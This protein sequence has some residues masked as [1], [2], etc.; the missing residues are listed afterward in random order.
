MAV[1]YRQQVYTCGDYKQVRYY[2]VAPARKGKGRKRKVRP[3][4]AAQRWIN[5]RQREDKAARLL[6]ANF[7]AEDTMLSLTYA[8]GCQPDTAEE[9]VRDV[10]NYLRRVKY[11][12]SRAGLP[13]PRY[14]WVPEGDG[15]NKRFHVHMTITSGLP[16]KKLQELWGQVVKA[17]DSDLGSIAFAQPLRFTRGGV[18]A[19]ARYFM[20]ESREELE[21]MCIDPETGEITDAPSG[22]PFKKAY[23]CSQGL[24]DPKPETSVISQQAVTD[25]CTVDAGAR[26]PIEKRFPGWMMAETHAH[27]DETVGRWYLYA[28]LY[29]VGSFMWRVKADEVARTE[30]KKQRAYEPEEDELPW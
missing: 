14:I 18:E 22:S 7:S 30:K 1:M 9:V 2:T 27:Y 10:Q 26:Q 29:R 8:P 20:K 16:R 13:P 25:M 23:Y 19:L 24:V 21:Q 5:Q 15:V 28:T 12:R 17:P 6:N 11:T 3:T 4:K